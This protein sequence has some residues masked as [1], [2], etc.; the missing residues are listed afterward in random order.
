MHFQ[1]VRAVFNFAETVHLQNKSHAKFKAFTV[2]PPPS[3]ASTNYSHRY[4]EIYCCIYD[5]VF[6]KLNTTCSLQGMHTVHENTGYRVLQNTQH[7]RKARLIQ[8]STKNTSHSRY[9]P[10]YMLESYSHT[11]PEFSVYNPGALFRNPYL[12]TLIF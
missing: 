4:I 11:V 2:F 6:G 5:T 3:I 1:N 9:N 10:N 8:A 12:I 7:R